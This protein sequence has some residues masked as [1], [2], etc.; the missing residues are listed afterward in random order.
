M[1]KRVLCVWPD[2]IRTPIYLANRLIPGGATHIVGENTQRDRDVHNLL[3][4][5]EPHLKFTSAEVARGEEGLRRI[6][7]PGG[8][9]FVCLIV[10]DSAYLDT[11]SARDWSYH[12]YRDSDIQNYVLAAEEL[13]GRGYY[14]IRMGAAVRERL[15]SE[16]PLIIDYASNGMRSDF[17]DIYLGARCQFCISGIAGFDAVPFIFRRPIAWVNFV[18]LGWLPTSGKQF[19]GITKHHFS[20]H[21]Q[22]ELSLREVFASGIGFYNLTSAYESDGIQ[23]IENTS[24]EIRDVVVELVGRLNGEWQPQENDEA[25]QQ[26]FWNIFPTDA[27][28]D[29]GNSLHGEIRSKFGAAFL[30]NDREWLA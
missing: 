10:R 29:N 16:H 1:W 22:R 13:A 20:S 8:A 7:I 26:D 27:I 24:E 25:L 30:R 5:S 12:N 23:L 15:K 9:P 18:P 17:M 6:G 2:W 4:H 21:A 28:G 3:D 19:I 14:V 11:Q